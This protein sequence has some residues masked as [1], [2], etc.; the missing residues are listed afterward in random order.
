MSWK[1]PR[2]RAGVA[3]A[4]AAGLLSA[5]VAADRRGTATLERWLGGHPRDGL[6]CQLPS[7][8]ASQPGSSPPPMRAEGGVPGNLE[9]WKPAP[10]GERRRGPRTPGSQLPRIPASQPPRGH[11]SGACLWRDQGIPSPPAIA[12]VDRAA[13]ATR[14]AARGSERQRS[15]Q[16][17]SPRPESSCA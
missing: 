6:G 5:V 4:Q 11:R 12:S 3:S 17:E 14:S 10:A 2:P 16:V 1:A 8:P 7:F 9:I 13:K 15:I